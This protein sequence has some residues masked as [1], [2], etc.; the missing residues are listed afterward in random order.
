MWN[1]VFHTPLGIG[2]LLLSWVSELIGKPV[3]QKNHCIKLLTAL[4][5]EDLHLVAQNNENGGRTNKDRGMLK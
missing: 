4:L 2:N 1:R 3:L 5:Q